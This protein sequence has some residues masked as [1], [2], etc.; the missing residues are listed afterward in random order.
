M[1]V[2]LRQLVNLYNQVGD[3]LFKRNVRLGIDDTM[4][5]HRA[6][7]QTLEK[8]PEYFW[9]MNNGIT[10]LVDAPV[11]RLHSAD[12]LE[13]GTLEFEGTPR[14]SVINGAQTISICSKYAFEWE[15]RKKSC[16]DRRAE[17]KKRLR[18]FEKTQCGS[19]LYKW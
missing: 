3:P 4:D 6:M 2:P 14:F 15:Y 9:Y 18:D 5:V 17:A 11:F 19:I 10:L 1:T 13:L 8:E 16:S 7:Y 12:S